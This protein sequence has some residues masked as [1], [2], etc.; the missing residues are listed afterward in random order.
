MPPILTVTL[1]DL[2]SILGEF[3]SLAGRLTNQRGLLEEAVDEYGTV[4]SGIFRSEGPGWR[5]L[6]PLTQAKRRGLGTAGPILSES[7]ALAESYTDEGA[8][9]HLREWGNDFVEVG[10]QLAYAAPHEHGF[11]NRGTVPKTGENRRVLMR[12]QR[13]ASRSIFQNFADGE[14]RIIER[15]ERAVFQALGI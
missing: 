1:P 11:S 14:R 12:G 2:P 3:Q 8:A 6:R 10:S 9:G 15:Y 5:P 13:V 7:G 4:V